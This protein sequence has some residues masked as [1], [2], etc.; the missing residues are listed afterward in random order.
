MLQLSGLDAAFLNMETDTAFGH[1]ATL[2][3]FD[4]AG[5]RG[6]ARL[7]SL[8]TSPVGCMTPGAVIPMRS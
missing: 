7:S 2:M 3:L 4:G 8:Y 5:F 6:F 1:V